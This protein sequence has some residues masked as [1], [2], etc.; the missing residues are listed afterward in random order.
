MSATEHRVLRGAALRVRSGAATSIGRVRDHNEDALLADGMVFAV[1]DG[2]GGHAAGEVASRIAVEALAHLVDHPPSS[3]A[4]VTDALQEANDGILRSQE[5]DPEQ[6]GMGTT[7]TGLTVL[8]EGGREHWVVFNIGD[9]RVYRVADERLELLTRDH[10]EVRELLDAG[11]IDEEEAA[12]HPMRNIITRSLGSELSPEADLWALP[13]TAGERFVICS[14][15]LSNELD[16]AEIL[17]VVL[18]HGDPQAA[19]DELVAAAVHAGGRDNVS[20][21]VVAVDPVDEDAPKG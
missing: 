18:Q 11:L 3:E 5:S 6:H 17:R 16:D 7:V 20:V 10:S 12:R 19:A 4:D 21:V 15:G 14:D 2:M 8:D 13:P 9:S 1:A